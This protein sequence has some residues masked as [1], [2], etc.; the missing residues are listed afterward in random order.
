MVGVTKQQGTLFPSAAENLAAR[1]ATHTTGKLHR[2]ST[3]RHLRYL[4]CSEEY[5]N[6]IKKMMGVFSPRV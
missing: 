4:I 3:I 5:E 6:N 2:G 1:I